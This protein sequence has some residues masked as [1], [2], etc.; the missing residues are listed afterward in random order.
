MNRL[1]NQPVI[2]EEMEECDDINEFEE[3]DIIV[4]F[5][6]NFYSV[7]TMQQSIDKINE[8]MITSSLIASVLYNLFT[9]SNDLTYITNC[10]SILSKKQSL[11]NYSKQ[12]LNFA[13]I[14]LSLINNQNNDEKIN[15]SFESSE[16]NENESYQNNVNNVLIQLILNYMNTIKTNQYSINVFKDL[17]FEIQY[18]TYYK[19]HYYVSSSILSSITHS[20]N[21][22][23]SFVQIDGIY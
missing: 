13:S 17:L 23:N 21:S 11:G 1:Q 22:S 8:E 6:N 19:N 2:N 4:S 9:S 3:L 15:D 20:L 14:Y 16:E 10:C 18:S 7:S 12:I 5:R